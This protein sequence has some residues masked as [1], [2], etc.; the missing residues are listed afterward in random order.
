MA[1]IDLDGVPARLLAKRWGV[2]HVAVHRQLPSSL[3]AVHGL[4]SRGAPSGAVVLAEEQTA[5]RGRDGR[6]WHSPVG[7]VWLAMLFRPGQAELGAVSIRA[8]LVLADAVDEL[9]GRSAVQLKWPNDVLLD[10]RKLAGV[11]C[12]GRWQ[13]EE[14]QWLAVGIGVNV[15]NPVPPEL[16]GRAVALSE[17]LP[18]VRRI[19]LLDC[20]VPGLTC[21]TA[22]GVRLTEPECAAFA[23]RDCLR[24][25]QLRRPLAGRG[26]G[27]RPDGALLVE[28]E[29]GTAAVRE[30]RV[31]L[32]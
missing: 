6:T 19:D 2:P 32:A 21:L 31:E 27:L 9:L 22:Y 15:C 4:G 8:G 5:G 25:R 28:G 7:G 3:D 18:A 17:L 14:L 10:G 29:S 11:L 12:E 30:G 16:A 20:L 24:G 26:G 23:A 1:G 13:G